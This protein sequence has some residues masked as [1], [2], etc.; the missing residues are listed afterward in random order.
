MVSPG[1]GGDLVYRDPWGNPYIITLDLNYDD[2]ARDACYCHGSI[3][4]DPN[5][6]KAGLNGLV[7]RSI[8]SGLVY[9]ANTPVMVWSLGPDKKFNP[10]V[11][12]TQGVN[13]D[14]VLS[15]K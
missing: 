3:S 14:N 12:A 6:P 4:V 9:E 7:P 8:S 10:N 1:V 5:N 15:W 11:P 2:K 13:K